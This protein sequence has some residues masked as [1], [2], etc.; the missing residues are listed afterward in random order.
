MAVESIAKPV[1]SWICASLH[2]GVNGQEFYGAAT[3][4]Q[5]GGAVSRPCCRERYNCFDAHPGN[6]DCFN[7]TNAV[8]RSGGRD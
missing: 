4:S 7:P 8:K 1:S 2:L 6:R 3:E 5:Q